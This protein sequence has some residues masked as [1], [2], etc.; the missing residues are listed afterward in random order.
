MFGYSQE[1]TI[2]RTVS[3]LIVPEDFRDEADGFAN[4][5]ARGQT[6]NVETVRIRKDGQRIDVSLIE[7]PLSFPDETACSY[8]IYREITERRRLE[9]ELQDERDRLRLLLDLN[10]RVASHLDLY[11]IFEA[12]SS[13]LRRVFNCD[14]VGLALPESCGK[15]LR[16]HMVD[17]PES[18]GLFKEG[19]LYPI[20][21]SLSGVAFRKVK[22]VLLNKG[23]EGR[24]VWSS[25]KGFYRQVTDEG[26]FQSGWF[27][28]LISENR[29]LGVLQLTSREEHSFAEQDIE[30]LG[31]VA[32]Q[33]AIALNNALQ[34][35][36]VS[37]TKERLAEQKLYLEDEIRVEHN[38]DEIVGNS[39]GLKAVLESVQIVA[40]ADSS[41]LI[42]GE[43][44]QA[45][46]WWPARFTT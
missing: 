5:L 36:Q 14:F 43:L 2:G 38:F 29:V 15:Y 37:E 25:D 11:R 42:Y 18:K 28:P 1:E 17:F 31:Q 19:A 23:S 27:V 20:E 16:Q 6:V 35:K 24:A 22:P 13:E 12:I 4:S 39:P 7:V 33:I 3:S 30:F 41:V 40:P 10:N 9:R 26:P 8:A 32:N 46:S 21:G 44:V 34:Y 45:K